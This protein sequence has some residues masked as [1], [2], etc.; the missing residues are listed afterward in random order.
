M[1]K[2]ATQLPTNDWEWLKIPL[3]RH[4]HTVL[5]NNECTAQSA[6]QKQWRYNQNNNT[7]LFSNQSLKIMSSHVVQSVKTLYNI[8]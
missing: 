2:T 3:R 5:L 4:S 8:T 1:Q 6:P 7:T